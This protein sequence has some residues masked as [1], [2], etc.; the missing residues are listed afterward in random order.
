MRSVQ[1]YRESMI[2]IATIEMRRRFVKKYT[3]DE[4]LIEVCSICKVDIDK[5]K[6]SLR[7]KEIVAARRLFCYVA[8]E[9][10][11]ESMLQ[12]SIA[13][14]GHEHTKALHH[15]DTARDYFKIKDAR[16]MQDW[17]HYTEC[18]RIWQSYKAA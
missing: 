3:L 14:G 1:Q 18:S 17:D 4:I 7:K 13:I 6:S 8:S 15:R 12:I 5:V 2:D 10:T 16:F 11:N 9:I